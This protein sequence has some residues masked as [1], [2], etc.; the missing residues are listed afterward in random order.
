MTT[1]TRT[2]RRDNVSVRGVSTSHFN[3]AVNSNINNFV[4]VR[5]NVVG[6]RRGKPGHIPPVF[7]PVTVNGVTT[8]GA[9]VGFN[10]GKPDVSVIATYTSTAGSVKRT[11]HDVGRNCTS[12]VL[13]N[14]SRTA[15]YR[16][17]VTN[18]TTL[19]TLSADASPSH[20]SVPFSGRQGNFIVNRNTNVLVLRGLSRTLTQ[21]TGVLTRIINCNIAYS[22]CRVATPSTS[23][24]NTNGTVVLT[25]GRTNVAPTRISCV[26]TRKADA[27]TGSSNR[28][29]TVGCTFNRRT[30]GITV[31]DAGDV[32]KRLLNTTNNV[33]TIT[34]IGTVR[35][36]FVP[37]AVNFRATSRGYSL[38]CVPGMKHRGRIA[39]ALDGS[40]NFNNRGTMLYFGG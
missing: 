8:K 38:S 6:V 10:T 21:N 24:D 36:S 1:S 15:I 28:A 34:Y 40:L 5:S 4:A 31:S 9:T 23:K 16:V 22:T 13:T 30:R 18:F 19:A 32:A 39:C 11:F 29:T 37:P 7:I 25:V 2:I 20:T 17:N 27:P 35:S 26:G 14:K 33:R 12:L 3:I